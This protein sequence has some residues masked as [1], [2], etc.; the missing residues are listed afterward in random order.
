[1]KALGGLRSY[2]DAHIGLYL[3]IALTVVGALIALVGLRERPEKSATAS[4]S[5]VASR[6]VS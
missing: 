5:L 3:I 2:R 1:V 6:S 4:I